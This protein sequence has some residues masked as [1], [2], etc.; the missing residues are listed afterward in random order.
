MQD[1]KAKIIEACKRSFALYGYKGTTIGQV[2]RLAG[3]GKG[4][5]YLYFESKEDILR[6]IVGQLVGEMI[7]LAEQSL[8]SGTTL[9]EKLHNAL[10]NCLMFRK[11]HAM[12]AKLTQ[13]ASQF[14]TE[15]SAG[16]L[17]QIETGLLSYISLKLQ[18]GIETGLIR[19]V[20]T[21]VTSYALLKLYVALVIDWENHGPR[22]TNEQSSALLER[23]ILHGLVPPATADPSIQIK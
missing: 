3:I 19:P 6:E 1:K 9:A 12:L 10:F 22:L 8:K 18:K 11:E 13:E 4:T 16:A 14:G 20:E 5:V 2:A 7:A 21:E 17:A 23:Y 15:P